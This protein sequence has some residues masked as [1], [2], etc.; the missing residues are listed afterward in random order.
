MGMLTQREE[1]FLPSW[2][3]KAWILRFML[4]NGHMFNPA[5]HP[6][7]SF[8]GHEEW[9]SFFFVCNGSP[10]IGFILG[11]AIEYQHRR[12]TTM[13]SIYPCNP[14]EE[15]TIGCRCVTCLSVPMNV[16]AKKIWEAIGN[17][18]HWDGSSEQQLK[19]NSKAIIGSAIAIAPRFKKDGTKYDPDLTLRKYSQGDAAHLVKVLDQT[20]KSDLK[21]PCAEVY[22]DDR[23]VGSPCVSHRKSW[24]E[25][26]LER[27]GQPLASPIH[28]H[29]AEATNL[30]FGE[31]LL[32]VI[33]AGL[34]PLLRPVM[35][36]K[37]FFYPHPTL[38]AAIE[39]FLGRKLPTELEMDVE[40]RPD[41]HLNMG[42]E[43]PMSLTKYLKRQRLLE[44]EPKK[45]Q[46]TTW[47]P[48]Y[49]DD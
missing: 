23:S 18:W 43:I 26:E 39:T 30:V 42:K 19:T 2:Y 12:L 33:S 35:G 37:N 47:D 28:P 22:L 31:I 9:N 8:K 21:N 49:G 17:K 5:T 15:V 40:P 4:L 24:V 41:L 46:T 10:R 38:K 1:C 20:V 27:Y 34:A 3:E 48:G 6:S 36:R 29:E 44:P 16:T 45:L 25:K 14:A 32:R 11:R 7:Y 13:T